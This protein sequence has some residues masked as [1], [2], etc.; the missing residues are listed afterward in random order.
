MNP[1]EIELFKKGYVKL[2]LGSY[3]IWISKRWHE[4]FVR[5]GLVAKNFYGQWCCVKDNFTEYDRW[6]VLYDKL[7]H[8]RDFPKSLP[9][10]TENEILEIRATVT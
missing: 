3:Y 5:R 1:F 4:M 6:C 8:D 2:Q 10:L 9:F 7:C